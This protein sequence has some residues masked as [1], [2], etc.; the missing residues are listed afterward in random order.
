MLTRFSTI[1]AKLDPLADL[2]SAAVNDDR[3]H[4]DQLQKG[5]IGDDTLLQDGIRHSGSAVFDNYLFTAELADIGKG[6]YENIRLL[7]P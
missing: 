5:N 1:S 3:L 4:T 2:L 7:D 6:F